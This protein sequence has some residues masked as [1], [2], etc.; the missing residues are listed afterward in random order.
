MKRCSGG[1]RYARERQTPTEPIRMSIPVYLRLSRNRQMKQEAN[2][3]EENMQKRCAADL[4]VCWS[5][6]MKPPGTRVRGKRWRM[7]VTSAPRETN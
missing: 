6:A 7:Q 5:V 3:R 2:I 1:S 4:L